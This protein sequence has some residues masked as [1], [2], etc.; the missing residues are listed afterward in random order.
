MSDQPE[1]N[2][3]A[4]RRQTARGPGRARSMEPAS[5]YNVASLSAS[6]PPHVDDS[7]LSVAV[8]EMKTQ[9]LTLFNELRSNLIAAT[10]IPMVADKQEN[11]HKAGSSELKPSEPHDHPTATAYSHSQAM[12]GVEFRIDDW[13]DGLVLEGSTETVAVPASSYS[14]YNSFQQFGPPVKIESFDGDPRQWETFIGSFKALV[15]DVVHSNVQRVAILSQPLSPRLRS[16]MGNCLHSPGMYYE[17]LANLRRLFGD[18][19][20]ATDVHI[21]N[22]LNSAPMKSNSQEEVERF[23]FEIRGAVS[24]FSALKS[25]VVLQSKATLH[26]VSAKRTYRL[27][28]VWAKRAFDL[29]PKVATLVEFDKWLEE[30]IIVQNSVGNYEP[31]PSCGKRS[32][33]GLNRTRRVNVLTSSEDP[34]ICRLCECNHL[35]AK[36]PQFLWLS[37]LCRAETLK[38]F[39]LCFACFDSSHKVRVYRS[40]NKC[41]IDGCRL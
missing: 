13:I 3:A 38:N 9:L 8:T 26:S 18:P 6:Y 2:S 27:K 25:D 5:E 35:L 41:A 32:A 14:P 16:C 24:T 20:R 21:H 40:R 11:Q 1:V 19:S 22:L 29:L 37:P 7:S 36:C 4:V 17:A 10:S 33:R 23:F 30:M 12:H 28:G 39:G 15:H 34:A 31:D